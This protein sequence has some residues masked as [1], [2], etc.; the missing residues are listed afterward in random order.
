MTLNPQVQKKAQDEIDRV[1]GMDRLPTFEDKGSLPYVDAVYR[2]AL[3]WRPV[4]PLGFAHCT[5]TDD[6]YK[7]Y[8][9]P[10]G[11]VL[12]LSWFTA[13]IWRPFRHTCHGKRLV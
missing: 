13:F 10:K 9:I 6:V 11:E 1:I 8:F 4:L 12:Q 3:R 5:S 7:G 2:E